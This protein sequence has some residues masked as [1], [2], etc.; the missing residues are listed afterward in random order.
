MGM[1]SSFPI[2]YQEEAYDVDVICN[3]T[4]SS[5]QF[6]YENRIV[7]FDVTGSDGIIGFCRIVIPRALMESPYTILVNGEEIPY[8]ELPISNVTHAFLY[9]TYSHS[10]N[11][12]KIFTSPPPPPVGG[13]AVP[14]NRVIVKPGFQIPWIWLTTIMLLLVTTV[15]YVKK[16]KRDT[17]IFS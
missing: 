14:I 5:F 3:S 4:I 13:E 12:I 1:F 6:D 10:T 17:E 15:V 8:T 9:F 16:R 7:E 11:H 2:S